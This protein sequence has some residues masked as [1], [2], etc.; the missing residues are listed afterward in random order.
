MMCTA[1]WRRGWREQ[2]PMSCGSGSG[3]RCGVWAGR[4]PGGRAPRGPAPG[5]AGAG[6]LSGR[7]GPTSLTRRRLAAPT[8]RFRHGSR[9]A[10]AGHPI[11]PLPSP[12]QVYEDPEAW[13]EQEFEG[14]MWAALRAQLEPEE[15]EVLDQVWP[16][17]RSRGA[18][19]LQVLAGA[20][21]SLQSGMTKWGQGL[22]L[23]A[24]ARR[25]S[26]HSAS[27]MAACCPLET[28]A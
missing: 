18:R 24:R 10:Q 22:R 20:P 23:T 2:T 6:R 11:P 16:A 9:P 5:C 3:A 17:L 13:D 28:A 7:M 15:A 25:A 26:R 14:R 27:T 21:R 4:V 19:W 8:R 12:P 1:P